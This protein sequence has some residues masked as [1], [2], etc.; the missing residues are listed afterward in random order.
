[1]NESGSGQVCYENKGNEDQNH[2]RKEVMN[3]MYET[4]SSNFMQ[5]PL[6]SQAEVVEI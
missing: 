1:M 3:V 6:N 5:L 4:Y 2:E